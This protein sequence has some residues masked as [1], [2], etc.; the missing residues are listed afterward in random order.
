MARRLPPAFAEGVDTLA[1]HTAVEGSAVDAGIGVGALVGVLVEVGA[2]DAD[3]VVVGD[4]P[5]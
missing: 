3:P 1:D 2:A 4:A 5:F